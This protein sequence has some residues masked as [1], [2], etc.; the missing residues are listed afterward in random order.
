M[1]SKYTVYGSNVIE[2]KIDNDLELI[3]K[4]VLKEI[5]E[6]DISA[7]ILG[8]GY[9]RGEGGVLFDAD[10]ELTFNDYDFF[11][12]TPKLSSA[13]K[14]HYNSIFYQLHKELTPKIGIDVDF[15][16]IVFENTIPKIPFSLMWFELKY[17]H[18]VIYGN[19]KILQTL[20]E[21][22]GNNIPLV[23][24][25]NLLLNRAS[26]LVFAEKKIQ[27]DKANS[28]EDIEFIIR[29]IMKARIAAGDAILMT[30]RTYDH[31][32][33]RRMELLKKIKD[34]P[35]ILKNNFF[36]IYSEAM[37]Y[38]LKPEHKKF[39]DA[40]LEK[41]FEET[42]NVYREIYLYTFSKYF[43]KSLNDFD[44][45]LSALKNEKKAFSLKQSAK[46]FVLNF[47]FDKFKHPI[48]RVYFKYPRFRLFFSIPYLLFSKPFDNE[49]RKM[50]S[51]DT[52]EKIYENYVKLW[53]RFN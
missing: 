41:I 39:V 1:S 46:N 4:T 37:E 22:K 34:K 27:S 10:N 28:Q 45:Y 7:L 25:L 2:N 20:P 53:N 17:G 42:K 29:N 33:V 5:P 51:A 6:K 21:Y 14:K 44:E 30:N 16:P 24:A 26:G 38:K 12:I 19:K 32:Y 49:L 31:S 23:E 35:I 9:G 18:I 48:P 40:G 11:V 52:D 50:L 15:G 8:G 36:E 13:R 47:M 43:G 3:R